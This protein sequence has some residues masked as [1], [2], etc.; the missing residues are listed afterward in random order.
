MKAHEVINAIQTYC[1]EAKNCTWTEHKG[2]GYFSA[3]I[4]G[5][6]RSITVELSGYHFMLGTQI[7]SEEK[8]FA[9]VLAEIIKGV[10]E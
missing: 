9:E 6:R 3:D 5:K 8:S 2:M 10:K 4:S 1:P 7:P